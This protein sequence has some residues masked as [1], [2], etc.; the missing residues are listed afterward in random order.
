MAMS[1]PERDLEEA[2]VARLLAAA[3]GEGGVLVLLGAGDAEVGRGLG[4]AAGLYHPHKH[5]HR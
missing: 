2:L 1:R 3:V 4:K 5:L